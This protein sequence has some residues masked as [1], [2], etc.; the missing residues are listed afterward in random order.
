MPRDLEVRDKALPLAER[1]QGQP[2]VSS[3]YIN[4]AKGAEANI[5]HEK[6]QFEEE[7]PD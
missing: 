4:L 3:F 6:E 2:N 5:R 1:F 7:F